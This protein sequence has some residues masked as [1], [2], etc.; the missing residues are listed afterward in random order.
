ME[1]HGE[2]KQIIFSGVLKWFKL[3]VVLY[4]GGSMTTSEYNDGMYAM[5]FGSFEEL[6]T[7][8]LEVQ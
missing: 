3:F 1:D 5:T 4:R 6:H 2:K 7:A 8:I